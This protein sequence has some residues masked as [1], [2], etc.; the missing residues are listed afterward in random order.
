MEI[1]QTIDFGN[2]EVDTI[3]ASS[4]TICIVNLTYLVWSRLL[5]G[6]FSAGFISIY[7]IYRPLGV[8]HCGQGSL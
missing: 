8:F 3:K 4:T 1:I 2:I 6:L 5:D 7:D